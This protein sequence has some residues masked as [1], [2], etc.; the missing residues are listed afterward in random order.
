MMP[1]IGLTRTKHDTITTN[2]HENQEDDEGDTATLRPV[3]RSNFDKH[4]IG[5]NGPA[6]VG[7]RYRLSCKR[8][9]GNIC[10]LAKTTESCFSWSQ[11]ARF[12]TCQLRFSLHPV[13]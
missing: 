2:M 12:K 4:R 3:A 10:T 5:L 8:G 1:V 9:D 7:I 6:N 11:T 13:P